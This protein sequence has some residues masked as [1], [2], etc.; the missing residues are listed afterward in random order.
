MYKIALI[1]MPFSDANRPALSL[2][3]LKHVVESD[4]QASVDIHYLNQEFALLFGDEL[5]S[6]ISQEYIKGL[7]DWIFRHLVFPEV[8]GDVD[9][10]LMRHFPGKDLDS[11]ELIESLLN[12]RGQLSQNLDALIERFKLYEADLVGF[13]SMFSQNIAC[14]ALAK[15]LKK[16]NK[17]VIIVMGG[18]NCETP[19][20]E[21]IVRNVPQVDFVFSGP[22]T[23][24]FNSFI[25]NLI[26]GKLDQC[27]SIAGVFSKQNVER[28]SIVKRIGEEKPLD[29]YIPL[30][31]DSFI[32]T[33][34][35]NF[36]DLRLT[37]RLL[38]ETSRGCWWGERS[39]C[40]FC[41]LNS[42]SMNYRAM[43]KD[44]AVKQFE[45]IFKYAD[46]CYYFSCVD[47][48]L[49]QKYTKDVIPYIY[50]PEN[51]S[52]FYEVKP[53]LK[54]HE[55]KLLADKK[56]NALQPG[57]ESLATSTLI[58]MKKGSNAFGNIVFLKNSLH[59]GVTPE[60]NL[61]VGFPGEKEA[62]YKKY[63][64]ELRDLVHLPPPGGCFP[65]RFDRYSP[66]F[67]ESRKY[68][69]DLTP[70]EFYNHIYPF[71]EETIRDIAYYFQDK[72]Y[73]AEYAMDMWKWISPLNKEIF[74][75]VDVWA[76]QDGVV[77]PPELFFIEEHKIYDSRF[78][79]PREIPITA[80]TRRILDELNKARTLPS[81]VTSTFGLDGLYLDREMAFIKENKLIFEEG[82]K[83]LSL[84]MDGKSPQPIELAARQELQ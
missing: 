26:Q 21:Q 40:T 51:I 78:V 73:A 65:V 14:F 59:Y 27:H 36:P 48:I 22:S 4:L 23:I 60:W 54:K 19:M 20:G 70:Y 31:Y 80:V 15:K 76:E 1:N 42:E 32:E 44:V 81:L 79:E 8:E 17:D 52:I 47:N 35:N 72:N 46:D 41:G 10:Y 75:W 12:V 33:F 83:Y 28:G 24:S 16:L 61:L 77:N 29:E 2:T 45:S 63:M 66:Y 3:Q 68:G 25:G 84:V 13:T 53:S 11:M 18:A 58:L 43:E 30:D 56:I 82:N 57:I 49:S 9:K 71:D 6:R 74:H 5:Y 69:L 64:D 38:F 7:G 37:K 34:D 55:I 62:V 39:H 67:N 50:P